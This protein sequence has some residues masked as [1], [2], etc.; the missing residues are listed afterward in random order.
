MGV[1]DVTNRDSFNNLDHW[2]QEINRC[3]S[4][5]VQ[6]MVIGNKCDKEED[7][8]VSCEEGKEFAKSRGIE[9]VECSA[10]HNLN[11]YTAFKS[12]ATGMCREKAKDLADKG[13]QDE[14]EN[15]RDENIEA[16]EVIEPS[17]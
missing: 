11:V 8:V 15:V 2:L 3:V 9:Y 14:I 12:V 4:G 7:R 6:K 5:N 13:N 1:F 10:K 17:R 16:K